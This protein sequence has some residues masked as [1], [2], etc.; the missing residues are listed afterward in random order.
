MPSVLPAD[1]VADDR[2]AD[3]ASRTACPAAAAS[4]VQ[5]AFAADAAIPS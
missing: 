3:T 1:A 2:G 5:Q 4:G